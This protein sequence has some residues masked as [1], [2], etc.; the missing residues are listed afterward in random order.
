[1]IVA[2][3]Q[4]NGGRIIF[5]CYRERLFDKKRIL[6]SARY[7]RNGAAWLAFSDAKKGVSLMEEME[8][9]EPEYETE[10]EVESSQL[11]FGLPL[12]AALVMSICAFMYYKK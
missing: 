1:M 7:L 8:E 9:I 4:A 5:D 3:H 6:Q 11:S 2:L 12:L 10:Y